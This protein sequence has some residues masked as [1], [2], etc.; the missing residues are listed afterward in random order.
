MNIIATG[1]PETI[2]EY[3]LALNAAFAGGKAYGRGQAKLEL[4]IKFNEGL[5]Q[6]REARLTRE[7][8][9][10]LGKYAGTYGGYTKKD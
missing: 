6:E 8:T 2:E 9:I 3:Q 10:D 5:H 7:A 4:G 1:L